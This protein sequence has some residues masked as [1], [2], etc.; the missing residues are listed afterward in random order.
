MLK[1]INKLLLNDPQQVF[2][3]TVMSI[4]DIGGVT[5]STTHQIWND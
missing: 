1:T 4:L 2:G 5:C 3:H